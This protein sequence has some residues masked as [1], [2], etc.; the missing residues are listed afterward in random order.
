M[1]GKLGSCGDREEIDNFDLK[2]TFQRWDWSWWKL[3]SINS[4]VHWIEVGWQNSSDPG[5]R[6]SR[7]NTRSSRTVMGLSLLAQCPHWFYNLL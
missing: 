6:L 7:F 2:C 5:D 4:A 3:P 1:Q